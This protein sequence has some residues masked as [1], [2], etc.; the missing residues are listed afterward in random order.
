MSKKPSIYYR[1]G[2]SLVP[3]E[4]EVQ[5]SKCIFIYEYTFI[6]ICE[7]SLNLSSKIRLQPHIPLETSV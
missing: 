3:L 1:I 7:W 6:Y 2:F 5:L 4:T